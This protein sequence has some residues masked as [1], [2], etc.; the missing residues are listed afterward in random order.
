LAEWHLLLLDR[1]IFS[2]AEDRLDRLAGHPGARWRGP[3]RRGA[4][5]EGCR[6]SA[7][8]PA[9]RCHRAK[10]LFAAQSVDAAFSF[11]NASFALITVT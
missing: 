7:W 10:Y 3:N 5:K 6:A 9:V 2:E 8:Q 4:K 11:G 1:R